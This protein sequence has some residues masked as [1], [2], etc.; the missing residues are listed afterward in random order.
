MKKTLEE[1]KEEL[2]TLYGECFMDM[3]I[4]K[5]SDTELEVK[6]PNYHFKISICENLND[7]TFLV[8]GKSLAMEFKTLIEVENALYFFME[9]VKGK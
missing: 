4:F 9:N 2:M 1:M 6:N 7:W 5:N 8:I 3:A